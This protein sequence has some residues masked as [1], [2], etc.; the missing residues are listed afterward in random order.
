MVLKSYLYMY[1]YENVSIVANKD[2]FCLQ[3]I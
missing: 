2:C 1:V 3:D